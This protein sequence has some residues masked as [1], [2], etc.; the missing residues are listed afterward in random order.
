MSVN[1][2]K[3]LTQDHIS[4]PKSSHAPIVY[5]DKSNHVNYKKRSGH[6]NKIHVLEKYESLTMLLNIDALSLVPRNMPLKNLYEILVASCCRNLSLIKRAIL[7]HFQQSDGD[8]SKV[9]HPEVYHFYPKV[10]GHFF[11]MVYNGNESEESLG[12]TRD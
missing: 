9:C 10:C 5:F 1:V 8:T 12:K 11:T 3:R 2:L 6:F 4:E 7:K